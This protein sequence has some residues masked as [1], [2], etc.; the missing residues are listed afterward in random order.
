MGFTS[1]SDYAGKI[2]WVTQGGEGVS[3]SRSRLCKVLM[4]WCFAASVGSAY[5][6]QVYEIDPAHTAAH[7]AVRHMMVSTV[8]GRMGKVTGTVFL[9]EDDVTRSRVEAMI[10]A[11]E[12][13]TGEP[14]RDQHLRSADFLDTSKYSSI[15]F[16]S[17]R[18]RKLAGDKYEVVGDL[19]MKGITKEVTLDVEGVPRPF[20]DPFGKERMGGTV[21]TKINRQDFGVNFHKVMDN[22]GLLVGNDV[23]ITIDV[24]VVRRE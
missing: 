10:D 21:R 15:S 14:K 1:S 11:S 23:E 18:V 19:T 16:R 8:R 2:H 12:I 17:K 9:E 13:D 6:E 4:S 24:E 20:I 3:V 5:A 22:G 7:F